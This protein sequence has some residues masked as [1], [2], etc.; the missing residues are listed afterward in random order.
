MKQILISIQALLLI[1]Y[2]IYSSAQDSGLN[3]AAMDTSSNYM[4]GKLRGEEYLITT[5]ASIYHFLYEDF[6]TGTVTLADDVVVE[7]IKIRYLAYRDNLI[8]YNFKTFAQFCKLDK[9]TI[10]EFTIEETKSSGEIKHHK[11]IKL[12]Y[13]YSII[14]KNRYFEE[15][16]SGNIMLLAFHR[17]IKDHVHNYIDKFGLELDDRYRLK[18]NYYIYSGENKFVKIESKKRLFLKTFNNNKQEVKRLLRQNKINFR[19]DGSMTEAIKLI[20]KAGLLN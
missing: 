17:V 14:N 12:H 20:D 1:C 9:N 15:L 3:W 19:K 8:S 6:Y 11:F 16:Y 4:F 10:K 13:Q 7:N 18:T 5:E 2:P